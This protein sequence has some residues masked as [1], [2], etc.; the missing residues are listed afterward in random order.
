MNDDNKGLFGR[1]Q[2]DGLLVKFADSGGP[3][4]LPWSWGTG[5]SVDFS[6][7]GGFDLWKGLAAKV[8]A[9]GVAGF[10]L[11]YGEETVPELLGM[12]VG[13]RFANGETESTM[14]RKHSVSFHRAT[15]AAFTDR[16]DAFLLGR[17]SAIGGQRDVDAIWP[18]D[19][20]T[21][22][23]AADLATRHVG[24]LPAGCARGRAL[25]GDVELPEL[26]LR[27]RRLSRR[28][29]CSAIACTR[30]RCSIRARRAARCA[31]RRVSGS[32]CARHCAG[33]RSTRAT[34]RSM[35]PPHPANYRCS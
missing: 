17:A 26:R 10:K 18:G 11:D 24:G 20:D 19:L 33:A 29:S 2:R 16:A 21:D 28:R 1:A 4:L 8:T 30:R 27:H 22:F 7:T 13:L 6:G 23:S 34:A 3:F 35:S 14:H 31:C 9:M 25:A 32:R 15:R 12:R 5:A